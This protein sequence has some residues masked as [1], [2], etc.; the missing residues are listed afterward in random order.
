MLTY[1]I[2]RS[3]GLM[4]R[5][6]RTLSERVTDVLIAL[7]AGAVLGGLFFLCMFNIRIPL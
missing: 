3:K 7:F 6:K 5:Y 2:V 4:A 1:R